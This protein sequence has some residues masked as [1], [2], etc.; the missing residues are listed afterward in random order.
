MIEGEG[1]SIPNLQNQEIVTGQPVQTGT[2]L[3]QTKINADIETKKHVC[4]HWCLF[5]VLVTIFVLTSVFMPESTKQVQLDNPCQEN[6]EYHFDQESWFE[7]NKQ[8]FC[9]QSGAN[10]SIIRRLDKKNQFLIVYGQFSFFSPSGY[11]ISYLNYTA[12][13]FGLTKEQQQTGN[14]YE[15]FITS[16]NHSITS[17]CNQNYDDDEDESDE[18]DEYDEMVGDEDENADENQDEDE[19]EAPGEQH[20]LSQR[21]LDYGNYDHKVCDWKVLVY[22]PILEYHDYLLIINY[23]NSYQENDAF[24]YTQGL[25]VDPRYSNSVLALRYTF[26]A[27]SVIS[28]TLFAFRMKKLTLSNWVIEQKFVLALSFLLPWF[29]DPLYA[30]TLMAPNRVTAVIGVIFFS[31]FICCLFLYWL[32]LYH[33]IVVDNGSKESTA[34]TKPKVLVCF[35]L[36]LF[37]V[38]SYSIL[39]IQYFRDPTTNFDDFH[40]KAYLAFKV[41]SIIFSFAIFLYL[42]KYL[43]QFCKCHETRLWRYKLIGLFNI[44]F[45]MCLGLFI[46]SGSFEIYNLTGTE[47]LISIS[48]LNLYIYYQQYLWSPSKQGLAQFEN[49]NQNVM[50][51]NRDYDEIE[52]ENIYVNQEN[53]VDEKFQVQEEKGMLVE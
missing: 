40:N 45:M 34:V 7:K 52:I 53:V 41:L 46:L 24:L 2:P 43:I 48:I 27:F 19:D 22:I 10:Y 32:V 44:F 18:Y 25:T 33:R 1:G 14:L 39:V 8:Q 23:A 4:I 42:L 21:T 51:S 30:A 47:V 13:L 28:L 6:D 5:F 37:F 12:T 3:I 9:N 29:N 50:I 15:D 36:W 17:N 35:L 31:N 49:L 26:F 20:R 16:K 38:V 11:E